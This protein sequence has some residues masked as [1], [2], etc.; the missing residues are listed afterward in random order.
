MYYFN[1]YQI[2]NLFSWLVIVDLILL[3]V[4]EYATLIGLDTVKDEHLMYIAREGVN[5]PLPKD[6]K[7]VQDVSG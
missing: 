4:A 2:V 7:P 6:W 3:E 1:I 5:A